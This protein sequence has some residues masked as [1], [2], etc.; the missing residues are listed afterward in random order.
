MGTPRVLVID[1]PAE[2]LIPYR[3]ALGDLVTLVCPSGT[4]RLREALQQDCALALVN[5]TAA[6]HA[7][8]RVLRAHPRTHDLPV[9]LLGEPGAPSFEDIGGPVDALPAPVPPQRLR[10]R[11]Q[12]FLELHRARTRGWQLS[13]QFLATMLHE[14]RTPLNAILGWTTLLRT[15][16]VDAPTAERALETIERNARAQ[17]HLIE[18]MLDAARVV[19]GRVPL[20]LTDVDPR[21]VAEAALAAATADADA[22]RIGLQAD[23]PTGVVPLRA[24]YARLQQVL[25]QLLSNA[26][27]AT[28]ESGTVTLRLEA[29]AD[30][31]RITVA[32]TGPGIAPELL[33]Q[34]FERFAQDEAGSG[35][36]RSGRGLGLTLV[37]RLVELHGGTVSVDSPGAG[38]GASFT[39]CL[40]RPV[41][42]GA[43]GPC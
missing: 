23:L 7:A 4:D 37:R 28:P 21:A 2:A 34:L 40:P 8:T 39:V 11:V 5:P 16:R 14:L 32:D 18:G 41:S 15:G 25:S 22:R 3:A 19:T 10:A 42:P 17:T 13:E 30:V 36:R 12:V 31:V 27:R 1:V 43:A 38:H 29:A 6:G 33:P 24:D 20:E 9:L 26:I 35:R